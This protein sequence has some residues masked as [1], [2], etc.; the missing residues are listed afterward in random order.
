MNGKNRALEQSLKAA[1][2]V[3]SA[4]GATYLISFLADQFQ[5][6]SKPYDPSGMG[7]MIMIAGLLGAVGLWAKRIGLVAFLGS[8]G[9]IAY[10]LWTISLGPSSD[11]EKFVPVLGCLAGFPLANALILRLMLFAFVP[12]YGQEAT[13]GSVGHSLAAAPARG[14]FGG[15]LGIRATMPPSASAPPSS[16]SSSNSSESEKVANGNQA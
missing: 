5:W 14:A 6:V 4:S 3:F 11:W 15:P 1:A 10:C 2:C 12:S 13:E 8:I 9:T 16:K 7:A